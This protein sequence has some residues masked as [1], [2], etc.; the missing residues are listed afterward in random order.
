MY[1][2]DYPI[3]NKELGLPIFIDNIGKHNCQPHTARSGGFPHPQIL[4]C[5][6]GSGILSIDGNITEI[7]PHTAIFLPAGYPHEYYPTSDDW[8]I[9]WV[10]PDGYACD[11]L[12]KYIGMEKP[13]VFEIKDLALLEHFFS[14]MH[15]SILG[16]S[17]NGN[18]RASGYLYN[19]LIE[20][21][22]QKNSGR[23]VKTSNRAIVTA[24]DHINNCYMNKITMEELCDVTDLS[25]QQLCR[26]F[27]RYLGCRPMEYIAKRRIQTAKE[28]LSTTDMSVEAISEKV[29]FCSGSYFTKLFSR[30]EGM[31]PTQF[32]II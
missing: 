23:V 24:I 7:S 22:Q 9:H 2:N 31:T 16:D 27:K 8:D 32:R 4:Y 18:L 21:Y 6:K 25:K 5:T 10:V 3:K 26:L 28:L 12:L 1:F 29:G 20:L 30:Y 13:T 15:E 17:I 14:R 11:D 19:F